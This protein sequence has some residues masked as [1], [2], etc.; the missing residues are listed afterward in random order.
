MTHHFINEID[1]DWKAGRESNPDIRS[2]APEYDSAILG[3]AHNK[4]GIKVLLYSAD[5]L[6]ELF[7]EELEGDTPLEDDELDDRC[8]EWTSIHASAGDE[9]DGDPLVVDGPF[10]RDCATDHEGAFR[11][12]VINDEY[13]RGESIE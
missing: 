5:A 3:I 10:D 1:N 13:W 6:H 11:F 2:L 9:G 12:Y 4:S 7:R 8:T